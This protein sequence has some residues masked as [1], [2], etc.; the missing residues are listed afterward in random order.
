MESSQ[1][2]DLYT[3]KALTLKVRES[4]GWEQLLSEGLEALIYGKE[5]APEFSNCQHGH[6][7]DWHLVFCLNFT[8]LHPWGPV[9]V[10]S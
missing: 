4:E 3:R 6:K 2:C 8:C 5:I 10:G 1:V 9:R 7:S